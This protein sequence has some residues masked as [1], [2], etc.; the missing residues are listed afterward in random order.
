[1]TDERG[2]WDIAQ[3]GW[4][5]AIVAATWGIILRAV[6]AHRENSSKRIESRLA[7]LESKMVAIEV[8]LASIAGRL[9][10]RDRL[11]RYTWPGDDK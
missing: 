9:L 7:M 1:M 10:E 2:F 3:T 4:F 5:I 11:G 6:L 8:S